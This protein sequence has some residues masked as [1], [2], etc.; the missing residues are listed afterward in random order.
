MPL[1]IVESWTENS[2]KAASGNHTKAYPVH[3]SWL[4]NQKIVFVVAFSPVS[5]SCSSS[6]CYLSLS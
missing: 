4:L 6:S 1:R 2:P 3:S 5:F